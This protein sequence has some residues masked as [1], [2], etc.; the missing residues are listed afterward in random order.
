[1]PNY[2][3]LLDSDYVQDSTVKYSFNLSDATWDGQDA[4]GKFQFDDTTKGAIA[5]D[6]PNSDQEKVEA[7]I[8]LWANVANITITDTG[9][10]NNT[11]AIAR[12]DTNE[13]IP[14]PSDDPANGVTAIIS[15]SGN[16][17]LHQEIYLDD[18][19]DLFTVAGFRTAV[20]ELGHALIGLKDI[21]DVSS[22]YDRDKTI[23]SYT[24]GTY[25]PSS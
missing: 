5:D 19:R 17:I 23:M 3:E 10:N 22:A 21:D 12:A 16:D 4:S 8:T 6:D 11:L 13:N 15:T 18:D 20:H 7:A 2:S 14:T 9:T 25:T 24:F 1:M